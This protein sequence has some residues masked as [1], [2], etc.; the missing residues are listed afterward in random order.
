M[1]FK[2]IEVYGTIDTAVERLKM[3]DRMGE[4]V[5]TCFNG[6]MLYS[7]TVTLDGAYKAITGMTKAEFEQEQEKLREELR[8]E[9]AEWEKTIPNEIQRW[10]NEGHAV[11]D[12][13]YWKFWDK[14]VPIRVSDIYRGEEL[15]A[16]LEIVKALNEGCDFKEAQ[17]LLDDQQHSGLSESLVLSMVSSFCDRGKEFCNERK[18]ETN[19]AKNKDQYER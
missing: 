1:E 5:R 3:Y 16:T 14:C 4:K 9:E 15:G 8:A 6:V 12:E 18:P 13:K 7:D 11:L 2:E 19:K 10:T 17:K